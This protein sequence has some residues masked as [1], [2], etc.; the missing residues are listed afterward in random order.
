MPDHSGRQ[1]GKLYLASV[2]ACA[3]AAQ[4]KE[5]RMNVL[6]A[7]TNKTQPSTPSNRKI[8]YQHRSDEKSQGDD[9]SSK[10]PTAMEGE[11]I[12][13]GK[14]TPVAESSNESTPPPPVVA[15]PVLQHPPV[16]E[17]PVKHATSLRTVEYTAT[18]CRKFTNAA[19]CGSSGVYIRFR[20]PSGGR[21]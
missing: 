16:V 10:T 5:G 18:F 3:A 19:R 6:L 20:R 8:C 7:R 13:F 12:I 4:R 17:L 1:G 21:G 9:A 15:S 11:K 2:A 14:L